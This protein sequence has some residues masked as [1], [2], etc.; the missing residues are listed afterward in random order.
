VTEPG[1]DQLGAARRGAASSAGN[2]CLA[3]CTLIE[4]SACPAQSCAGAPVPFRG[5]LGVAVRPQLRVSYARDELAE[6]SEEAS[7]ATA[8]CGVRAGPAVAAVG[9]RHRHRYGARLARHEVH[10]GPAPGPPPPGRPHPH[11]R[12]AVPAG[13]ASGTRDAATRRARRATRRS[14]GQ[15]AFPLLNPKFS[16]TSRSP[17]RGTKVNAPMSFRL[18]SMMAI[19]S[20]GAAVP[21]F[22]WHPQRPCE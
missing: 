17:L 14:P 19:R 2:P 4:L 9:P 6:S 1:D 21:H 15:F 5:L 22:G 11:P 16:G 20:T 18:M 12:P 13:P 10:P 3:R 8:G 7:C